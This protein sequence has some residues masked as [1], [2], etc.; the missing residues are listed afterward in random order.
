[1]DMDGTPVESP[2]LWLGTDLLLIKQRVGASVCR[3]QASAASQS[4]ADQRI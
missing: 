2:S 4:A 3:F 1:M